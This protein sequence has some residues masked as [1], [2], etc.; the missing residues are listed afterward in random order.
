MRR[1]G[2]TKPP[3]R[4][5]NNPEHHW[6]IF[7]TQM[8]QKNILF[9]WILSHVG[10]KGNEDADAAEKQEAS[11]P[12]ASTS[13]L[14]PA[15]YKDLQKYFKKSYS[16]ILE[17]RMGKFKT[18]TLHQIRKNI[19][20]IRPAMCLNRKD[21]VNLTRVRIGHTN[22]THS[23]LITKT[24][25]NTCDSCGVQNSVRHILTTCP[26][27]SRKRAEHNLQNSLNMLQNE[28]SSEKVLTVLKDI[29]LYSLI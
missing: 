14:G 13:I 23:Y 3:N 7:K 11:D 22:W 26:K 2:F 15:L 8:F 25:P 10:I 6:N 24:E 18:T 5:H 28:D 29:G 4:K 27:Y 19:N 17:R 1:I 20:D 12:N 21:Q 16:S 9:S